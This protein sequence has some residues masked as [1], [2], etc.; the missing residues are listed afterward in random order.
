MKTRL[1]F[2]T[3]FLL[4]FIVFLV[5]NN[6]PFEHRVLFMVNFSVLYFFTILYMF[7]HK[8]YSPFI[9]SYIVFSYLF[10]IIAPILQID[11]FFAENNKRLFN[12]LRYSD[13]L[14]L[15][16]N[17][18]IILFNS[19]FF[20]VYFSLI[21]RESSPIIIKF[22][23]KIPFYI[24]LLFVLNIVVFIWKLDYLIEKISL[25]SFSSIISK[26]EGIINAK[27]LFYLPLA[28][29]ILGID[30]IKRNWR[31]R[32]LNFYIIVIIVV[33]L[34][35]LLLLYKNPLTAKRNA[36]GPI[37]IALMYFV[38]SKWINSN[39]K[40]LVILFFSLIVIF[41]AT[42][43]ITHSNKAL[44]EMSFKETFTVEHISESISSQLVSLNFDAFMM[45]AT[46]IDYTEK[47]GFA[48]GT[49]LLPSLFFF[50]PRAIWKD[51]PI[52]TGEL[53]GEHIQ[54]YHDES[55]WFHNLADPLVAE[56][57]VDF[58]FVGIIL[59][60]ILLALICLKF[61]NWLKSNDPL[62]QFAAFYFAIHLIFLLRGD[63]T[64]GYVYFI[65]P[66]FAF[67]VFPKFIMK[68]FKL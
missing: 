18:L 23:P 27:F 51:K 32:K 57:Y 66:F 49:Q 21:K 68:I 62:R 15:K 58:G 8:E 11:S 13:E 38:Y 31:H 52:T 34:L 2:L 4:I 14:I 67:Y 24:L 35:L 42:S 56:S 29:L 61:V 30:Y 63:L 37:Y 47:E 16:T 3:V 55:R 40:I 7:N 9:A 36:L 1:L 39:F 64:N 53:M 10:F 48:M 28:P 60:G 12:G 45:V 26:S 41:P 5:G 6:I 22:S 43:L 20:L 46:T 54:K 59:F 17:V 65:L 19:V 44:S 33:L 50:I 25:T